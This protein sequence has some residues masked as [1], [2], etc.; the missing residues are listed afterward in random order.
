VP[1]TTLAGI[2]DCKWVDEEVKLSDIDRQRSLKNQAREIESLGELEDAFTIAMRNGCVFPALV[3]YR[4]A[5]ESLITLLGGNHRYEGAEKNGRKSALV[6]VVLT[7]D[8]FAIAELPFAL[9]NIHGLRPNRA[10]AVRRA[11]N[12]VLKYNIPAKQAAAQYFLTE[13]SVN[14]ALRAHRT[15]EKL[16]DAGFH[17]PIAETTLADLASIDNTNVLVAVAGVISGVHLTGEEARGV[18]KEVKKKHT[19]LDMIGE[20]SRQL[21]RFGGPVPSRNGAAKANGALHTRPRRSML[22]RCLTSLENEIRGKRT[23]AQCQ[24]TEDSEI[25]SVKK[26]VGKLCSDLKAICAR[27]KGSGEGQPECRT[28]T[29]PTS[30]LS[31][32]RSLPIYFAMANGTRSGSSPRPSRGPWITPDWYDSAC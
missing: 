4:P 31:C 17:K 32:A 24:I 16:V 20:V 22:L 1:A 15:R 2:W 12:A 26:R 10:E 7:E 8:Q 28:S 13:S 27:D 11:R 30:G 19:E 25:I 3:G 5:G 21:D 14:V 9:N 18:V 23:L 29:T 6:H